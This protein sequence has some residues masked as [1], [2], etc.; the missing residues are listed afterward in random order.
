MTRP[1]R[2]PAQRSAAG[3]GV[4]AVAVVGSKVSNVVVC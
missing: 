3:V 1:F 4:V 2:S